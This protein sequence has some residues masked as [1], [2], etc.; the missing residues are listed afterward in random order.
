MKVTCE[1]AIG[2]DADYPN[3]KIYIIGEPDVKS[4]FIQLEVEGKVFEVRPAE[5]IAAVERTRSE[6]V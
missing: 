2:N 3:T 6:G 1:L 4:G 5:L